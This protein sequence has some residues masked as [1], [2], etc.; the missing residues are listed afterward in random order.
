M[1]IVDLY[2][3]GILTVIAVSVVVL[4]VI[5]RL[6]LPQYLIHRESEFRALVCDASATSA[7]V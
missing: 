4:I 1:T 6:S 3:E 7:G 2:T 5:V